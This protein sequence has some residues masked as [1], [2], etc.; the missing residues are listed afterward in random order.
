VFLSSLFVLIFVFPTPALHHQP[1][2][3]AITTILPLLLL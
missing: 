1:T 3:S 2:T